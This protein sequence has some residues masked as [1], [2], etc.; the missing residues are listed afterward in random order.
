MA[1]LVYDL[2]YV[3]PVCL[4]AAIFV[5]GDKAGAG[6]ILITAL[7]AVFGILLR[8][9]KMR[10]RAV[11]VGIAASLSLG[12]LIASGREGFKDIII[13]N[14]VFLMAVLLCV[15]CLVLERLLQRYG[16]G[17]LLLALTGFFAL[18]IMM[19]L[20]YEADK[21][22]VALILFYLLLTAAGEIQVKWDKGG[23]TGIRGH[24]ANTCLFMIAVL[25]MLLLFKMPEKPFEWG[26]VK[27]AAR[28]LKLSFEILLEA[29]DSAK[30]WDSD[31]TTVGFSE[32][33]SFLGNFSGG[34]YEAVRVM[35]DKSGNKRIYLGGKTFDTFDGRSWSKTDDSGLDYAA[36]D[37]LMTMAAVIEYDPNHVSDHIQQVTS[38][39]E[40][41]GIRTARAFLPYKALAETGGKKLRMLG[42]DALFEKKMRTSY[43]V[44]SYMLNKGH[45]G[46]EDFLESG[47]MPDEE[48]FEEAKN[49]VL[50]I[51]RND[52]TFEG[53][54]A[55]EEAIIRTYG[56]PVELSDR[57]S[58]YLETEFAGVL[59]D[60][61]VS[62]GVGVLN[63]FGVSNDAGVSNDFGVSTGVG[64]STDSG[65]GTDAEKLAVIERILSDMTY[66][67]N[68]GRLPD[69]VETPADFLDYLIFEKKEGYCSH[70]ATAFV[71][72]ARAEGI[73]ARYV[74]GYSVSVKGKKAQ[75]MSDRAHAWPE[76]YIKGIGWIGYEPTPGFKK[77]S[78]WQTAAEISDAMAS[79]DDVSEYEERYGSQV[80]INIE[81]TATD[82]DERGSFDLRRLFVP[83]LAVLFFLLIFFASDRIIKMV[84]Y[85]RMSDRDKVKS[86]G[87]RAVRLLGRC[88]IRIQE[89][90]TVSEFFERADLQVLGGSGFSGDI[91]AP[92][93]SADLQA[94]G[95]YGLSVDIS[96]MVALYEAALYAP[97]RV[98]AGDAA[99]MEEGVRKLANFVF[100]FK[101][102]KMFKMSQGGNIV[103]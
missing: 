102:R 50:P 11:M 9:M 42:G 14:R 67:R 52:Y 6:V 100:K 38:T 76:A 66:R 24:I 31:E 94:H 22:A 1:E 93:S 23:D 26:F 87:K 97:C 3:L 45:A 92:R 44:R 83:A 101:M 95:N 71:L 55:Y 77:V 75:I 80:D 18:I 64:V 15:F 91:P 84:I 70:F 46:F 90:E 72:L 19:F 43:R 73:P 40:Y 10:G 99:Y 82:F 2:I 58:T 47:V 49:R 88:G 41:E 98:S 37:A 29:F 69:K 78:I 48:S 30:G 27:K 61:E 33:S 54:K 57:L 36:Y 74:Q 51:D 34:P 12:V 85:R 62:N 103:V 21:G 81:N 8:H 65:A 89:G 13:E 7:T 53:L 86:C 25:F 4:T 56:R 68:V 59:N 20:K 96:A 63:D 16:K 60:A 35:M 32:E 28:E 79:G 17:R 5:F 39:I